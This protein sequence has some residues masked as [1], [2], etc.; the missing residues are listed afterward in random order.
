MYLLSP[1]IGIGLGVSLHSGTCPG[2]QA[3]NTVQVD[4]RGAGLV[5]KLEVDRLALTAA[6]R[7]PFGTS[8]EMPMWVCEL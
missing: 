2:R 6:R 5:G 7:S 8:L 4:L 3:S 1:D